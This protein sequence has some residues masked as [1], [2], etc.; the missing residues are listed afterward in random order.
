[1]VHI[2]WEYINTSVLS[3]IKEEI[4][5]YNF[6]YSTNYDLLLY[7][8]LFSDNDKNGFFDYFWNPE[9]NQDNYF[10]ILNTQPW[11]SKQGDTRVLYLHGAIHLYK[12][13]GYAQDF[14]ISEEH[15]YSDSSERIRK[16]NYGGSGRNILDRFETLWNIKRGITPLF[17][18]E[19]SSDDKLK[20]IY[21][22]E[23][24]SFAYSEFSNHEG[25]LIVFGHSL[26]D[27][28]KHLIEAIRRS[29]SSIIAVSIRRGTSD[30]DVVARRYDLAKK[31][32]KK[33]LLFFDA[34][35]HPLG[36]RSLNLSTKISP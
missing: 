12:E 32:P 25:G 11:S 31:L 6:V 24:L 3:S 5:E 36:A 33:T 16:I 34:Q 10:S 26:G 21:K 9:S 23:Y 30:D 15:E 8:A 19:G 13:R 7:W 27:S 29:K 22:S 18:S 2:P 35:T 20:S 14:G 4:L 28:D 17:V 1:M